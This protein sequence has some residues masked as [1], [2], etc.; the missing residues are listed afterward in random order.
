VCAGGGDGRGQR[1]QRGGAGE[2][3]RRARAS[4]PKSARKLAQGPKGPA[5][6]GSDQGYAGRRPRRPAWARRWATFAEAAGS[7]RPARRRP[8]RS[9]S[10]GLAGKGK[11]SAAL[12][13]PVL[14]SERLR[15]RPWREEDLGPYAQIF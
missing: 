12:D 1:A 7:P 11:V 2:D 14:H 9:R 8:A 4:R 5:A 13:I 3:A 6:Q 15:L 10:A